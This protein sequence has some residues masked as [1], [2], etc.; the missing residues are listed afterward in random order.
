MTV[1]ALDPERP[2]AL[3]HYPAEAVAGDDALAGLRRRYN[4]SLDAVGAA[5]LGLLRAWQRPAMQRPLCRGG[6]S[7][8]R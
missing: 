7:V 6:P 2:A 3:E 4:E 1:R 8:C 5:G